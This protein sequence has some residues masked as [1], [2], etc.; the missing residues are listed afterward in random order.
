MTYFSHGKFTFDTPKGDQVFQFLNNLV[1]K[2]HVAPPAT[3]TTQ[4]TYTES[5]DSFSLSS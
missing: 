5:T 2:W 3:V 4:P 1:Y